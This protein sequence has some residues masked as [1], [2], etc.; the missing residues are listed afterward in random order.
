VLDINLIKLKWSADVG[1][2]IIIKYRY[3]VKGFAVSFKSP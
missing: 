3:R 2:A 1:S